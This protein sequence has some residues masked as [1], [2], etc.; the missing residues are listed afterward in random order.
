MDKVSVIVPT[1]N[2]FHYLLNTIKYIRETN[3]QKHRNYCC[4]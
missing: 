1:Y 4:K 2:R 3:I